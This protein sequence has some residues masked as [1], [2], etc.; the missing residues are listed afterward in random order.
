MAGSGTGSIETLSIYDTPYIWTHSNGVL[1][2]HRHNQFWFRS[3]SYHRLFGDLM[4][5]FRLIMYRTNERYSS[6]KLSL[7]A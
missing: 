4:S 7:M 3:F 1:I 6:R 2:S 5:L